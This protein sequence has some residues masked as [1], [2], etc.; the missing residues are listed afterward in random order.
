MLIV[1]I[2]FLRSHS[3]LFNG[4]NTCKKI[5]EEIKIHQNI[6]NLF[7]MP[8]ILFFPYLVFTALVCLCLLKAFEAVIICRCVEIILKFFGIGIKR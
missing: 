1:V 4:R 2:I 8:G 5:L 3:C 6:G 7:F